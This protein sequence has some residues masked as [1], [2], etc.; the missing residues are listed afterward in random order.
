MKRIICLFIISIVLFFTSM[1][2]SFAESELTLEDTIEIALKDNP[3]IEQAKLKL[4]KSQVDYEEVKRFIKKNKDDFK[5]EYGEN[6]ITY[7][8]QITKKEIINDLSWEIAQREYKDTIDKQIREVEKMYFDVLHA[9]KNIEIYEENLKL[10]N[11][12]YDKTQKEFQVGLVTETDVA[13][14]ELNYEKTFKGLANAQNKLESLKM[15]LNIMLGYDVIEY[16]VLI[17]ELESKAF[18]EVD[19]T[20]WVNEALEN[21]VDLL[22]AQLSYEVAKIEM[23]VTA[24]KYPEIVFEY[25]QKAVALK[26]AEKS[27]ESIKKIVEKNVRDKYSSIIQK[28]E[29]IETSQKSVELAQKVLTEATLSYDIGLKVLT[30]VQEAQIK[31]QTEKLTLAKDI[32]D[33]NLAILEFEESLGNEIE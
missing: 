7:L 23:E 4:E 25:R 29:E 24:K 14:S 16:I 10:A 18:E 12:L 5:E 19:I 11:D 33:Y 13:S 32:L 8:E 22:K 31:L 30:D 9:Q 1:S 27:L 17:D 21:N 3:T 20:E 6:S 26:E 28:E 15:E 2:P